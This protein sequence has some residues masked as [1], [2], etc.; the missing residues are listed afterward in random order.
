MISVSLASDHA[1]F[2][3]K[4]EIMQH[5]FDNIKF[6]DRGCYDENSCD[7]PDYAFNVVKDV[8][9]GASN[10]GVLI[11][12]TGIGMS[13][14]ANRFRDIR[15]ALCFNRKMA[16]A[17]REHNNANILCLGA[18]FVDGKLALDMIQSFLDTKFSD[19]S[20]HINRI[21][22]YNNKGSAYDL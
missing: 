16:I 1:A 14:S 19:L 12:N 17:S 18:C 21:Q 8:L 13:I 5:S 4:S 7:Y 11:C 3:L 2:K 22:K 9:S 6:I 20:R 10:F 15:A